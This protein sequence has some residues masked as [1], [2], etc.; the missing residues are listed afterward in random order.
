MSKIIVFD[1]GETLIPIHLHNKITTK[2][3]GQQLRYQNLISV[4]RKNLY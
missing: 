2:Q 4:L 1:F 3:K